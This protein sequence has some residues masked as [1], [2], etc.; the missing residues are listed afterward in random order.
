MLTFFKAR[1]NS[2]ALQ[3]TL[4]F[5]LVAFIG[6]VLLSLPI[7]HMPEVNTSYFQHLMTAISLVCVSGIASLP[8]ADTYN[9]G[10][11]IISLV[12]IQIGGLG[13]ITFLN[14]GL[15]YI[16]KNLSLKNQYLLQESLAIDSNKGLRHFLFTIYRFTFIVE[17]LGAMILLFDFVP[18]FGW[19][20][21]IFYSIFL[22]ISSFSNSGFHNMHTDS[23]EGFINNPLV[24]IT[25]SA[26]VIIGGLGFVVWNE[27]IERSQRYFRDHPRSMKLAFRNLS[28]HT[29]LVLK[30]SF[31]IT[32]IGTLTMLI[33][34]WANP[35][36][37]GLMSF[38]QKVMNSFF[39]TVNTRTAGYTSVDYYELNPFTKLSAMLQTIIGGAPG[40][41]AGGI[42]VTSFAI[43]V[44]II[45][46]ELRNYEEV[47]AF[48]R[49]I[50]AHLV[51]RALVIFVFFLTLLFV[52]YGALLLSHPHLNSMDL[53]FEAVNAVGSAGISFNMVDL[54]NDFGTFI[55]LILM[56]AGRVGPITLLLALLQKKRT[57]IH[58]AKTN[59]YIG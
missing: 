25:V 9:T 33:S 36:T 1:W 3:L 29:R 19:L 11:Q 32:L 42:K 31:F 40:G 43:I 54:L 21:G 38:P 10:G 17:V 30:V 51:K 18:R 52:G 41:T 12:L 8:L 59:I 48:K 37:I 7:F 58:Y 27:I 22:S 4:S 53:L 16:N 13:V 47:V 2:R 24:L 15:Y 35:A 49:V 46:S 44:L 56:I 28:V 20:D 39:N 23:L 34:E 57:E 55:I 5:L 26:L 50:P 6:S 45:R 14:V